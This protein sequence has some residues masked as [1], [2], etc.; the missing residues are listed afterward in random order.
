MEI[1]LIIRTAGGGERVFPI[2]AP[3]TVIGRESRCDLR[4]PLP[5]VERQHCEILLAGGLIELKDL[6]SQSG[7][8]CRG[9]RIERVVLGDSDRFSVGPVEFRVRARNNGVREG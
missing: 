5:S 9:Q 3:R 1:E 2:S 4:V 7:T 8:Y 6:G